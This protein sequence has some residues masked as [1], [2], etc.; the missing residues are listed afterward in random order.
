MKQQKL[1]VGAGGMHQAAEGP[2]AGGG[3]QRSRPQV[4]SNES[5][6]PMEPAV[7]IGPAASDLSRLVHGDFLVPVEVNGALTN[8]LGFGG[9]NVTL[10]TRRYER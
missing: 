6:H 1:Q 7:G 9:H 2:L 4:V 5:N 3:A 10:A 8:S